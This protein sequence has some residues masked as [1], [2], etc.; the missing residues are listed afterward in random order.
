MI[1]SKTLRLLHAKSDGFH[2]TKISKEMIKINKNIV[3]TSVLNKI[4]IVGL[5]WI[6]LLQ[7]PPVL[8]RKH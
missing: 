8:G 2:N 1:D 3:I 6:F 4:A 5:V 7:D